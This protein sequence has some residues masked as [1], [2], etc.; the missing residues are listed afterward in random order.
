MNRFLLSLAFAASCTPVETHSEPVW[1]FT[2]STST[3]GY[4]DDSGL[5]LLVQCRADR[6]L[7]SLV[8]WDPALYPSFDTAGPVAPVS[9]WVDSNEWFSDMWQVAP[10]AASIEGDVVPRHLLAGEHQAV[11]RVH[12]TTA[13]IPVSDADEAIKAVLR[14][15][16]EFVVD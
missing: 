12:G 4:V 5:A 8:P 15:C 6:L 3:A 11:L 7:T 9:W 13:I 14:V 2:A 1:E 10:R 16:G